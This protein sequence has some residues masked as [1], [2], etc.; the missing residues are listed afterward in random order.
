MEDNSNL[1]ASLLERAEEY[2]KTSFELIKLK[3][4]DKTTDIVSSFVPHT[5]VFVLFGTFML[6][7]NLGLAFWLGEILDKTFYGFLIV[8]G[9]W[10]FMAIVLHFFLHNCIK[11]KVANY[12]IH[13]VLK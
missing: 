3:T 6:F 2:G 4:I 8:G 1:I 12:F 11:R 13:L 5:L 9:F 7:S 10:G